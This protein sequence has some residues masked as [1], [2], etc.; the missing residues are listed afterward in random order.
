MRA[1]NLVGLNPPS[2]LSFNASASVFQPSSVLTA[3]F[4]PLVTASVE[5]SPK[6]KDSVV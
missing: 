1:M 2:P 4:V 3:P 6:L 5:L